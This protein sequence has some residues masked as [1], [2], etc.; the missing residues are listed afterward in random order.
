VVNYPDADNISNQDLLTLPCDVLIPAALEGQITQENAA[1]I[2]AGFI[3]EA[4]NGPTTPIADD[5]LGD[6]GVMIV[7]DIL[8]N[9]GGVIVSYFEWVQDLQA[10]S[11]DKEEVLRQ[12][13]RI[14]VRAYDET[15]HTAEQY[16]VNLRMAAQ[17]TAV[18]RVA[19]AMKTRGFY[20]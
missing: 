4:A 16:K 10:F 13:Q 15:I 8:A 11:W 6:M 19:D 17:I 14:M 1:D 20:P 7:P 12:L 2:Q 3:V 18:L 5:I 9:A